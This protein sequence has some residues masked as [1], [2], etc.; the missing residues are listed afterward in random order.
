MVVNYR[1]RAGNPNRDLAAGRCL[2]HPTGRCFLGGFIRIGASSARP[3]GQ[4]LV[5]LLGGRVLSLRRSSCATVVGG[6]E[7]VRQDRNGARRSAPHRIAWDGGHRFLTFVCLLHTG[8]GR[9]PGP[10]QAARLPA[11]GELPSAVRLPLADAS[12]QVPRALVLNR[13]RTG[14][15]FPARAADGLI[16]RASVSLKKGHGF[17]SRR[18]CEFALDL[19]HPN[20]P[21]YSLATGSTEEPSETLRTARC[22]WARCLVGQSGRRRSDGRSP[23]AAARR[24]ASGAAQSRASRAS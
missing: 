8:R 7:R 3:E 20:L 1:H 15:A 19:A 6:A 21:Q 14:Q 16:G 22:P 4:K 10:V 23:A 24:C 2:S 18:S 17:R 13:F 12:Q 9:L 11:D 5:A